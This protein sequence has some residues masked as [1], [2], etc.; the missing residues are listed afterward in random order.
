MSASDGCER[1]RA[2]GGELA[3]GTLGGDERAEVLEHLA[4]CQPCRRTVGELARVA[5]ELL[6]LAPMEEP[7]AGFESRVLARIQPPH[8]RRRRRP[9]TL[10]A[11]SL[12]AAAVGAGAMLVAFHGDRE[13]A[14]EYRGTL[15]Q[16]DGKDFRAAPLHGAG[17]VER[18]AAFG[19]QGSPSWVFVTVKSPY[20]SGRYTCELV[21]ARGRR[22][23]LR[24]FELDERTSGWGISIPVD[25]AD[26]AGVRLVPAGGGEVLEGKFERE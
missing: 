13:L 23:P 4:V 5:D 20:R 26:V 19:Y 3:L 21:T 7:P 15:A 2:L 10:A 16:A 14:S 6:L 24:S 17:E 18:G 1:V 12:A 22:I 9:A 11:A 8:P 25:L